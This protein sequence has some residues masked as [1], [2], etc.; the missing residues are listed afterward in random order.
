MI[1]SRFR[2]LPPRQRP[3]RASG[4]LATHPASRG[5]RS[6]AAAARS[7]LRLPH[8]PSPV[9]RAL[10]PAGARA[11]TR[12]QGGSAARRQPE[13]A[14]AACSV[15]PPP[16]R[17]PRRCRHRRRRR[18][19]WPRARARHHAGTEVRGCAR[20]ASAARGR[21]RPGPG[22][23]VRRFRSRRR[24]PQLAASGPACAAADEPVEPPSR[25]GRWRWPARPAAPLGP[26]R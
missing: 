13:R 16:Q 15:H 7:P 8:L 3:L 11:A 24:D 19:F 12:M 23:R 18:R 26:P 22:Q 5:P 25:V 17:L 6:L 4:W 1:R 9:L 21:G 20:R 14:A 2:S 10:P